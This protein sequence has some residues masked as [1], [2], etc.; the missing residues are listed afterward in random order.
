MSSHINISDTSNLSQRDMVKYLST[1]DDDTYKSHIVSFVDRGL[2]VFT[3]ENVIIPYTVSVL[4]LDGFNIVCD[5]TVTEVG[6]FFHK[7]NT[8]EDYQRDM[9]IQCIDGKY[10]IKPSLLL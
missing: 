6:V 10:Y 5:D 8:Q 4:A 7:W 3:Y 2:R 9:A 1:L